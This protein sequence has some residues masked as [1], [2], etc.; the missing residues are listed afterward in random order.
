MAKLRYDG[1]EFD[2]V[3]GGTFEEASNIE[4]ESGIPASDMTNAQKVAQSFLITLRRNGI[5][6]T[7]ADIMAMDSDLFDVVPDPQPDPTEPA[8]VAP[9]APQ[10]RKPRAR[11]AGG[12][13]AGSRA[14]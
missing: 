12:A 2:L 8:A 11:R 7:W 4:V 13:A 3:R 1:R 10:D 9:R 6:L 14:R 5:A